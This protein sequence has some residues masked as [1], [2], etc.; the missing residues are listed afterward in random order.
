M[1]ATFRF[2][3]FT[4]VLLIS[5]QSIHSQRINMDKDVFAFLK[6]ADTISV[7]HTTDS[8]Q[9]NSDNIS[10]REFVD[11][12]IEKIRKHGDHEMADSWEKT[13]KNHTQEIWPAA[14][15]DEL[16]SRSETYKN[17]I[18]FVYG[19]AQ[20]KYQMRISTV[21]VYFGYEI[22]IGQQPAKVSLEVSFY[23]TSNPEVIL[24]STQIKRAMGVYNTE[25]GDS[26]NFPNP[27][28]KRVEKAYKRAGYKF[29]QAL[30]R[31]ID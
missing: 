13:Y 14:F 11:H 6:T 31:I 17:P 4:I 12:I 22:G 29:A 27:S 16:N 3:L 7:V 23:D 18:T 24:G 9:F 10:E 15:V 2:F 28:V 1:T 5:Q 26:Q 8:I 19:N 25:R 30:K 21:W 20:T